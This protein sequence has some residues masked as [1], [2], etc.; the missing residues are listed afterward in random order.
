MILLLEYICNI[1]EEYYCKCRQRFFS[2]GRW[3]MFTLGA[4]PMAI[5][6]WAIVR[7]Y[8]RAIAAFQ[9]YG[10]KHRQGM[11]TWQLFLLLRIFV[12]FHV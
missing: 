11:M 5:Y 3:F 10:K 1:A 12:F 9:K 7:N 6:R 8:F 4:D 2:D